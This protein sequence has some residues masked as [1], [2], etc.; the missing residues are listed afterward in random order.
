MKSIISGIIILLLLGYNNYAQQLAFPTAEG[1]GKYTKGGRGG[2]VYEVTN[3]NTTGTGSLGAAISASGP[4]T[5]VFRVSGTIKGDFRINNDYIT[6]AGQTAPGDGITIK[7][8][9]SINSSNVIIRYIRVRPDPSVGE[10]DAM[11]CRGEKNII[12]DHVSVSWSSDEVLSVYENDSVTI[13]W[14]I[15]SEACAKIINGENTGHQFGGIWGN[16]LG[17]Y[18]HNLFSSN[19]S[20]NPRWASDTKYNDYRNNVVYNWGYNSC[21]GGE[22]DFT[23][24]MVANYYKAGPATRSNVKNRIAAPGEGGKW[25]VAD[26]YIDGYPDVTADNWL[27]MEG[28]DYTKMSSPWDA[29]A[30]NQQTPVEAY[31]S[32]LAKA[33]C[34]FPK[35]DRIDGHLIYDALNGVNSFEGSSYNNN[36][37]V[38]TTIKNGGILDSPY[39][40][41][42][43]PELNSTEAPT[44]SDYD[45]MPNYWEKANGLDT[46]LASDGNAYTLDT[47]YT[48]LEVYLNSIIKKVADIEVTGITISPKKDSILHRNKTQLTGTIT[49]DNATNKTIIYKS[50]APSIATVNAMGIVNGKLPGIVNIIAASQD[51]SFKDTCIIRVLPIAVTGIT[52]PDTATIYV[53]S[54][55]QLKAIIS[56]W[57][58][59]NRNVNWSSDNTSVAS[60]TQGYVQGRASGKVAIIVTTNDGSFSD[61]CMVTVKS[62]STTNYAESWEELQF[63]CYPNPF[64]DEIYFEISVSEVQKVLIELYD[65][66][67]K[68]IATIA[69]R[70][71]K[72]GNNK[73]VWKSSNSGV[74]NLKPGIYII[75][76]S[77]EDSDFR[78]DIKIVNR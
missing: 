24:N 19:A 70:D 27:G 72:A 45:G 2:K 63:N 69:C 13:Q 10:V 48:N 3:L 67:S 54:A 40:V 20:R 16:N 18:H 44:D 76:I 50:S 74:H 66:N 12:I 73:F 31:D 11:G 17:T 14:C 7:G 46:S 35:R 78:K 65:I 41:G 61:S 15:I 43:W 1:Y 6:I 60:V 21:Y 62:N 58:A 49:P 9:I 56:P 8:S 5:V 68:K 47:S 53:G 28:D 52:L 38:S 75:F 34:S 77:T 32:V 36:N 64:S 25:Y 30:I 22:N 57:D 23:V 55:I 37:P 42:G 51:G 59:S 26:N 33:G 71:F 39:D 29:M 4:R